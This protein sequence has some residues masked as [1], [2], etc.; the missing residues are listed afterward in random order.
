MFN[1]I[2]IP[3]FSLLAFSVASAATFTY[4]LTHDA[5]NRVTYVSVDAGNTVTYEYRPN[6][7]LSR[8]AV[9]GTGVEPVY[10]A[11]DLDHS[12]VVDLADV[13]IGLKAVTGVS[14]IAIYTDTEV[15][16]DDKIGLD[17]LIHILHNIAG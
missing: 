5:A 1:V 11:G 2:F 12:G 16:G 17:D 14:P 10:P 8:V 9:T 4:T 15:T 13:I 7:Q 6:G 3:F